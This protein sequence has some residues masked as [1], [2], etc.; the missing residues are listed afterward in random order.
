MTTVIHLYICIE[1]DRKKSRKLFSTTLESRY[2]LILDYEYFA[3][4]AHLCAGDVVASPN[5]RIYDTA[6]L[7]NNR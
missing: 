6:G 4:F 7:L 2:F 1:I 5:C 3:Y